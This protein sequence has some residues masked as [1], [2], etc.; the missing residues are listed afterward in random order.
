M[1]HSPVAEES[2]DEAGAA[3]EGAL[4]AA[5]ATGMGRGAGFVGSEVW[6]ACMRTCGAAV[7]R[8][9]AIEGDAAGG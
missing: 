9:G 4:F 1:D 6:G 2:G 7:A 5:V 3:S 8:L